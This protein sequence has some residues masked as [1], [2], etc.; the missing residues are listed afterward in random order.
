MVSESKCVDGLHLT[1]VE[2]SMKL[3]RKLFANIRSQTCWFLPH[4]VDLV[5]SLQ[6][7]FGSV[8]Q[9]LDTASF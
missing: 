9:G 3:L 6:T 1:D 8:N 4:W 7:T 5:L 2:G